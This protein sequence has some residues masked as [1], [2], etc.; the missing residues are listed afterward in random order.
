[1]AEDCLSLFE[2]N[3]ALTSGQADTLDDDLPGRIPLLDL[4]GPSCSCVCAGR[5]TSTQR[6]LLYQQEALQ[7]HRQSKYCLSMMDLD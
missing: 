1:M 2:S 6:P 5:T 4:V 3:P 7:Q